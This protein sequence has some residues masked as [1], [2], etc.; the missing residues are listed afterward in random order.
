MTTAVSPK[1]LEAQA[2]ALPDHRD[3]YYG[4][5]W[6]KAPRYVD[7]TSPGTGESLGKA[8]DASA[9]DV[10]AAVTAAKAA[11]PQWRRGLPLE[12]A[13]MLRR[14]HEELRQNARAR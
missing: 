9:A 11:F 12:R 14:S 10:D 7:A 6:H 4:G 1:S 2:L 8:A 5:K 3:L 13:K